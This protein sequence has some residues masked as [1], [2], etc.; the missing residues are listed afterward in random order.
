MNLK[1]LTLVVLALAFL[2]SVANANF[3]RF[4]RDRENERFEW[5]RPN[6]EWP[7]PINE[8][9]KPNN[10]RPRT[11]RNF[12]GDD[13]EDDKPK[14]NLPNIRQPRTF[15]GPN[16][17]IEKPDF[18]DIWKKLCGGEDREW[19][20]Q[21]PEECRVFENCLE[22]FRE[23]CGPNREVEDWCDFI[24]EKCDWEPKFRCPPPTSAVPEPSTYG[25]IGAG[26]LLGLIAF[27][28]FK[29]KKKTK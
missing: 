20:F 28:R 29:D 17:V 3:F 10:N 24:K 22:K 5:T 18:G 13:D 19:N 27:R 23:I 21:R 11:F 25:M 16:I 9:P 6:F 7:K 14:F 26:A 4:N 8:W 12:G 15:S 2:S 1:Q